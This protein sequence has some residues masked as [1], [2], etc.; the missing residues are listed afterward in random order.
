VF[1]GTFSEF[2]GNFQ[3]T[4]RCLREL[5]GNIQVFAG[6]FRK[7]SGVCGNFQVFEGTFSEFSGVC[8]NIQDTFRELSGKFQGTFTVS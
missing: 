6:T 7:F 1:A 8:R 2:S 3:G 4:F 5:S